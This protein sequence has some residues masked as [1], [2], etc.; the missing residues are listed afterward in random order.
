MPNLQQ[1]I[2]SRS[3][4]P[5]LA[6]V[7]MT[8][9]HTPSDNRKEREGLTISQLSCVYLAN[10]MNWNVVIQEVVAVPHDTTL[11]LSV[12]HKVRKVRGILTL[13]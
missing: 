4:S 5:G 13:L 7:L 9:R 2:S 3:V 1:N 12:S 8:G 10:L 6:N 11:S